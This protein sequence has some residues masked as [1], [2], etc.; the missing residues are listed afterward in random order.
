MIED[1]FDD[2]TGHLPVRC[3]SARGR[4]ECGGRRRKFL[5]VSCP[6]VYGSG[7]GSGEC[8]EYNCVVRGRDGEHGRVP[9]TPEHHA[10]GDDSAGGDEPC[11]RT[12]GSDP[13][14][15]YAGAD[16][17]AGVAMAS[18]GRDAAVCVWEAPDEPDFRG[19]FA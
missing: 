7:A 11:G 18:A 4:V 9:K 17:P 5:R 1:W 2:S 8:N 13:A 3:R 6:I 15:T 16:I 14:D 12:A 19:D 10:A